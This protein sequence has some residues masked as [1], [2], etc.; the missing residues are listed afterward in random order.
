MLAVGDDMVVVMDNILR[1]G[2]YCYFE[3]LRCI[4]GGGG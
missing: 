1:G 4:L 3:A 2:D